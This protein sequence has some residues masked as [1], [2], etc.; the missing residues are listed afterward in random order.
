MTKS[1]VLFANSLTLFEFDFLTLSAGACRTDLH[2]GFAIAFCAKS[3]WASQNTWPVWD[4]NI[5]VEILEK[6]N[7]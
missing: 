7:V 5:Q 2:I 6:N 1:Q 4:C 3:L